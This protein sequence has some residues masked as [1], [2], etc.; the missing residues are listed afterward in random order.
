VTVNSSKKLSEE[1]PYRPGM[2][3]EAIDV[4]AVIERMMKAYNVDTYNDLSYA[5]GY[6]GRSGIAKQKASGTITSALLIRCHRKTGVSIDWL[7]NGVS[8]TSEET[9]RAAFEQDLYDQMEMD[10]IPH[11]DDPAIIEWLAA[12]PARLAKLV[13]RII[14]DDQRQVLRKAG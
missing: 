14:N 5:L 4:K 10:I 3:R 13:M 8:K 11:S 2:M 12:E 7:V 6:L 1:K 9:L